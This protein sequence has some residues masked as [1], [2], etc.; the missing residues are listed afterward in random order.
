MASL[1]DRLE[2]LRRD[3]RKEPQYSGPPGS[4]AGGG[5]SVRGA[6][7]PSGW[8]REGDFVFRREQTFRLREETLGRI[9]CAADFFLD[10]AEPKTLLW[11]DTETTGLS[12]GAG[13]HV[14]LYGGA[15]IEGGE[16]RLTQIF[17]ADFP[18]EKAFLSAVTRNFAGS[19]CMLSYNGRAFDAP[20]LKNRFIVSR[21]SCR[22]PPQFD[23]LFVSRRLWK[24][25]L[26]DCSLG[27][28]ERHILGKNREN[29]IPGMLIPQVY[30]DYLAGGG[31]AGMQRVASH[32]RDDI[33]SLIGLFARFGEIIRS[34]SAFLSGKKLHAAALGLML[35]NR[36]PGAGISI[37]REAARGGDMRALVWISRRYKRAGDFS[38]AE[39][40]W[41]ALAEKNAFA[42]LELAKYFEHRRGDYEGALR[43]TERLLSQASA[44][45]ADLSALKKR[46]E[47]L[48][49]KLSGN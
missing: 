12:G 40:L 17:L 31:S 39:K 16:A 30:F 45:R 43:L 49:R 42:A 44:A 18:G 28:V 14:F 21:M 38:A 3:V 9:R 41:T 46:R 5:E 37:L 13:T 47:R 19:G 2:A 29:D 34:P 7:E 8:E 22:L 15:R 11:Y 1:K 23:L 25:I 6:P 20:L 36:R 26:P 4:S 35:E 24:G 32:H 48:I 27:S 33:L 10:R